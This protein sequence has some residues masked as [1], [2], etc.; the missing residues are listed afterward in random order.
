VNL[1]YETDEMECKAAHRRFDIST[2]I[3]LIVKAANKN[4]H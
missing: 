1:R 3:N 2:M 4:N